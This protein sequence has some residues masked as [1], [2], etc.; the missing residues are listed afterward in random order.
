MIDTTSDGVDVNGSM[1]MTGGT[2]VVSGTEDARNG[3]LDV[4]DVFTVSGGTLAANGMATMAVAPGEGSTQ[5]TLALTFGGTVPAD[6]LITI[7]DDGGDADRVLHHPEG[8]AVLHLLLRRPRGGSRLHDLGRRRGRPGRASAGW[9]STARPPAATPS[10]RSPRSRRTARGPDPGAGRV[11]V[12]RRRARTRPPTSKARWP[13]CG[14]SALL[15]TGMSMSDAVVAPFD[16]YNP[17]HVVARSRLTSRPRVRPTEWRVTA[18]PADSRRV[19][20]RRSRARGRPAL[21]V[22][23]ADHHRAGI[24]Q[25]GGVGHERDGR[26]RSRNKR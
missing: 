20:G 23:R 9:C 11:G 14:N 18:A 22:S 8:L 7:T 26:D 25:T 19:L 4:D 6:T 24:I 15:R 16:T 12:H 3:A 13:R 17:V 5:A 21:L 2:L 1:T 10:A